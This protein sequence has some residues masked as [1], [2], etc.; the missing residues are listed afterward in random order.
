MGS[1]EGFVHN[2]VYWASQWGRLHTLA[3]FLPAWVIVTSTSIATATATTQRNH[4]SNMHMHDISSAERWGNYRV[5]APPPQLKSVSTF[6]LVRWLTDWLGVPKYLGRYCQCQSSRGLSFRPQPQMLSRAVYFT[7]RN[8]TVQCYNFFFFCC[9]FVLVLFWTI[10][11]Y[12]TESR[13]NK[14][15]S[16]RR[17]EMTSII[18]QNKICEL[19]LALRIN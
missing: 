3:M 8:L 14:R 18:D 12:C 1:F 7:K 2:T 5:Y 6:T 4:L 15:G 17:V 9:F 13:D 19:F 16:K 10:E 11:L